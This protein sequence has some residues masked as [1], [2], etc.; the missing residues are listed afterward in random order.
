M[1]LKELL[2]ALRQWLAGLDA[3]AQILTDRADALRVIFETKNAM[4]ELLA[5]EGAYAPY[6]FV[7]FT[8]L[9]TRLDLHAEPVFSFC[10]DDSHTIAQILRELDRGMAVLTGSQ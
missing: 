4:A 3:P 10:D 8:V 6:R 5:G 7:S 1:N 9:D 2:N